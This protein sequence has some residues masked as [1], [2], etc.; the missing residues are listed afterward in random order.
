MV[1]SNQKWEWL[2]LV[3][4]LFSREIPKC[5]PYLKWKGIS[6]EV[7]VAITLRVLAGASYLDV[8]HIFDVS[9][10]SCYD[11]LHKVTEKWFCS[12][13]VS[14]YKLEKNLQKPEELYKIC[15]T[16]T[17]KG[18]S[19]G[20]LG[21]IIGALDGWLVKIKSPSWLRDGI[22]NSATYLSRKGFFALNVQVIVDREKRILW[23][24]ISSK[25]S[26]HDSAAFKDSE[27]YAKFE[28][29]ATDNSDDDALK[30]SGIQLYLIGDSAYALRPFLLC[31][32]DK[33]LPDSP[34]DIFNFMSSSN[35][36]FVE[37]AF[38]EIDA[39][40]GIF[41]RP[42]QFDLCRHRFIIDACLRLHNFIVN[43]RIN[44]TENL[45]WEDDSVHYTSECL[46]FL[47]NNPDICVGVYGNGCMGSANRRGRPTLDEKKI[48]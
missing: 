26:E 45:Q 42:L 22:K 32:Y 29:L 21:G 28:R 23:R 37:C 4:S 25:G 7:K 40:F 48:A 44:A 36:I 34:E 18:R 14:E 24:S 43:Y 33:A 46:S 6:G 19:N 31:P 12:D 8:A 41:W 10:S 30:Y 3:R 2:Y 15:E 11:I 20:I 9:Y 5:W 17:S 38:G 1:D 35:R 16:F 27:I 47:I 39:R 13:H